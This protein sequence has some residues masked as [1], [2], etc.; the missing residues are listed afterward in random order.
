MAAVPIETLSID[1][2]GASH[3]FPI[4]S[5]LD[6]RPR[7]HAQKQWCVVRAVEKLTHQV[8]NQRSAGQLAKHLTECSMEHAILVCDKNAV[9]QGTLT[10]GE[11]D[12]GTRARPG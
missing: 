11:F 12:A 8:G 5:L 10:Q 3:G 4:L 7:I 1:L 9:N 2:H 6:R